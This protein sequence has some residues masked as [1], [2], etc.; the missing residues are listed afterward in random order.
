MT[1]PG[2]TSG[3]LKMLASHGAQAVNLSY[4]AS[5]TI[6]QDPCAGVLVTPAA[7]SIQQA[8]AETASAV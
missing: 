7:A 4:S 3:T 2:A 6:C 5:P 8:G 1:N